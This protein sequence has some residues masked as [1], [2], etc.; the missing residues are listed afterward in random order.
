MKRAARFGLLVILTGILT[1]CPS[2]QTPVTDVAGTWTGFAGD[3]ESD[4]R[5][6][7]ITVE[8][9][10]RDSDLSGT[11]YFGPVAPEAESSGPVSGILALSRDGT[12]H[13]DFSFSFLAG[14]EGE[15][16]TYE[17]TGTVEGEGAKGET[18]EGTVAAGLEGSV[19]EPQGEFIL[20]RQ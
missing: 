6:T 9:E 17:F 4:T 16:A 19:L 13:V 12:V 18:I 11:G 7:P 1:A 8:L 14:S 3:L 5:K 2:T 10:Q 20:E 15:I